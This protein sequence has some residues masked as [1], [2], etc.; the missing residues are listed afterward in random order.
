MS[1]YLG[2]GLESGAKTAK[3]IKFIK[4]YN[5][6]II[7]LHVNYLLKNILKKMYLF[8]FISRFLN[9]SPTLLSQ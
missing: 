6:G 1:P 8:T 7:T 2:L 9:Y 3:D 4:Y 5:L